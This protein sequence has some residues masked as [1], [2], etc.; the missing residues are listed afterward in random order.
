MILLD[1]NVV[2]EIMR[3]QPEPN[4]LAWLAAQDAT[5]L[6]LAALTVA[7]IRRGLERLP[8]GTRRE[9]LESGFNTFLTQGFSGR[10]FP[11]TEST[12][13]IYAPIYAKRVDA[14]LGVGEI[15]LLIAAIAAENRASIAT[16]NTSD[17]EATGLK[18]INPWD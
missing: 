7:E 8:S 10:V 18:L 17:F 2:S 12:A 1:T 6:C 5:R 4:V 14:G 13:A 15:D 3:P 16:R 9:Q 11:F